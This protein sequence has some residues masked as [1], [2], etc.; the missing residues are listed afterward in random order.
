[1]GL[2]SPSLL[3]YLRTSSAHFCQNYFSPSKA[4]PIYRIKYDNN[5]TYRLRLPF[6]I[7]SFEIAIVNKFDHNCTLWEMSISTETPVETNWFAPK[8]AEYFPL[9]VRN[10]SILFYPRCA[11]YHI[12]LHRKN[13]NNITK[14]IEIPLE[15]R[16]LKRPM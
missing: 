13:N 11:V 16:G 3:R 12:I 10:K 9:S 5:N 15:L 1:M 14:Q 6:E 7:L 2:S 8:S 4:L